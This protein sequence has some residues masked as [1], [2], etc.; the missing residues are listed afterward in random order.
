MHCSGQSTDISDWPMWSGSWVF[1]L[2]E[3][4]FK[5][6]HPQGYIAIIERINFKSVDLNAIVR[7]ED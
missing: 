7:N 6:G 1:P 3:S 2:D 4:V 5:F